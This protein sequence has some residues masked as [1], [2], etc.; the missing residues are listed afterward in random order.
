M[1]LDHDGSAAASRVF[2]REAAGMV[3]ED[4]VRWLLG[5]SKPGAIEP[6]ALTAAVGGNAIQHAQTGL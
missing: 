3:A 5:A 2:A 4:G 1:R 6:A